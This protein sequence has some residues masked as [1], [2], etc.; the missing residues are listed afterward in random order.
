MRKFFLVLTLLGFASPAFS[1]S[2]ASDTGTIKM[3]RTGWGAAAFAVVL[4]TATV[5]NPAGCKVPDGYEVTLTGPGDPGYNTYLQAALAAY[6]ANRHV[7]VTIDSTHG[8][9]SPTERPRLI[10]INILIP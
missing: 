8:N 3:I 4:N 1:Q 6:V 9:C 2:P 7:S 10:G 5:K